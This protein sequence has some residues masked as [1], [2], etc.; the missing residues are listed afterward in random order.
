M[1]GARHRS[2]GFA[3]LGKRPAARADGRPCGRLVRA[4]IKGIL[5]RRDMT[6]PKHS[7]AS[8]GRYLAVASTCVLPMTA[9]AGSGPY[10]GLEGGLNLLDDQNFSVSNDIDIPP[11][12]TKLAK[13][14]FDDGWLAGAM[15][16]YSFENGL[17]PEFEYTHRNNSLQRIH[18]FPIGRL[19]PENDTSDVNGHEAADTTML[20]IWYDVK[21]LAPF[22]PYLGGGAGAAR[23]S[24]NGV[25]YDNADLRSDNKWLFAW[26]AGAGVAFDFSK[27]FAT[28]I[29][30]RYLQ[31]SHG[32]FNLQ[33]DNT[34]AHVK[35]RYQANAVMIGLHY[36]FGEKEAPPPAPVETPVEV[37]APVASP[38][39]P[40]PPPCEV[41]ANATRVDFS[42]CKTGD[43]VVLRGVNFDFNKST[44]TVNAK[45]LLDPV[46]DALLARPDIMIE[47]DG[48][49]DSKGSD[50]YNQKLSEARAA[51]V[52]AYL[53]ARGV[54]AGRMTVKGF[55]E[56]QPIA[57]NETE[58]GREL[59]RR[60]ELKVTAANDPGSVS[61]APPA[62]ASGDSAAPAEAPVEMLPDP[63][64]PPP[65]Q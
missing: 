52:Q 33:S 63:N 23:I 62:G 15:A 40:P 57:D 3:Q 12:G 61:V 43:T 56:T 18:I 46:A 6:K 17:R 19:V 29:D 47:V 50:A 4:E 27:H 58:A 41:S 54:D 34:G 39:P 14:K 26:Q 48:H 65:A 1:L 8:F 13:A 35:T 21:A 22:R 25:G 2:G 53:A 5:Q 11:G 7:A 60:V 51:S 30:Y 38:P 49:T 16:G 28:S 37:V 24:I 31:S 32:K 44:L 36:S 45:A 42:G 20:N 9:S 10:I 64:S 59:N 55:G